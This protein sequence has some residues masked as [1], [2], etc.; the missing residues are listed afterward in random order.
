MA[1]GK[2]KALILPE[3]TAGQSWLAKIRRF[4][5]DMYQGDSGI[6]VARFFDAKIFK[7]LGGYDENLTGAEDYDLPKRLSKEYSIGWS[8][9]HLI[10]HEES[11]GLKQLL[12]KKYYYASQSVSYAS[13]HPDLVASQG[14]ILFRKAY[15]R[16]WKK[17]IEQPLVGIQF[18]V[19]RILTTIWAVAGFVKGAGPVAFLKTLFTMFIKCNNIYSKD[20]CRNIKCR[21]IDCDDIT[22]WN[23]NCR[24]ITCRDITCWDI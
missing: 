22:C 8:G 16:N 11:L 20:Y 18:I 4:E 14:T 17:F 19:V 12:Q 6:E 9:S 3:R 5:R 24:N 21:D 15:L 13:K 2:H 23:I 7:K 1:K 10:H